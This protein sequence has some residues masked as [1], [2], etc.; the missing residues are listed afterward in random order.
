MGM[1]ALS[2]MSSGKR[3]SGRLLGQILLDGEFI[4]SQDLERALTEQK[5]SNERLGE[6]LVRIGALDRKDLDAVLAVQTQFSS[7]EESV[8]AAAGVRELLGDLL[9]RAR[10]ITKGQLDGV[11]AE[12][13]RTGEKLGAVLVR[14]GHLSG[15]ELVT[16][17]AF[18]QQQAITER[19][20]RLRL[21]ELLVASHQITRDQL[22]EVLARQK[23]TKKNIG[24]MLIEAGF[25]HRQ[26]LEQG[27][28]LQRKLVNAA[29]I[30]AISFISALGV[31]PVHAYEPESESGS[32]RLT[33][34]ARV[35]ARASL[36]VLAQASQ[37]SV[38]K[39]D[40]QRG[41]IDVPAAS[42]IEISSNSPGGCLLAFENT[43]LPLKEVHVIGLGQNVQISSGNG[44]IPRPDKGR[45]P[46][47]EELS[48]RFV[49]SDNTQPGTYAWP[50]AMS[51]MAR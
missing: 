44:W 11:L 47:Q 36:K 29:L 26:Q 13:K 16:M 7:R 25:V 35:T 50:L 37:L 5:R 17:L 1:F 2:T 27:L 42:R 38:T 32:A 24:E 49:L 19:P 12:Q 10:L 28:N 33:V 22:E 18:Q 46:T 48:Y 43:G 51:V 3:S 14:M 6:I 45:L 34:S 20:N 15:D 9:L 21:G 4:S 40:I 8:S 23:V 41:Y 30:A 39:E 31:A